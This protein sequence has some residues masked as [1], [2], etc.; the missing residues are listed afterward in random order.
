MP[1]I[2]IR[3]LEDEREKGRKGEGGKGRMGEREKKVLSVWR[4]IIKFD[5]I[6]ANT[7]HYENH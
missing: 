5:C 7:N 3:K 4:I 6:A 2:I 1:V